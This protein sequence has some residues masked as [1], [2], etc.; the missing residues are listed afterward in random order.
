MYIKIIVDYNCYSFHN[1]RIF[2]ACVRILAESVASLLLHVYEYKGQGKERVPQHSLY[3]LRHD[4]PDLEM[5][6]FIFRETAMIY[7]LLWSNAYAQI[8][9]DGMGCV[10]M[11]CIMI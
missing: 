11:M 1:E 3:F 7:L 6:F 8:L 4:S 9:R 2:Y 10:D 5:T